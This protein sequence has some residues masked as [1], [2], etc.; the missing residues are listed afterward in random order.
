MDGRANAQ[1]ESNTGLALRGMIEIA[2]LSFRDGFVPA[3]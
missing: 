2:L 3:R 1:A